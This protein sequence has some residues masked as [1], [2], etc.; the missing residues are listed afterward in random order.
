VDAQRRIETALERLIAAGQEIGLQVAAYVDGE[1]VVDAWA[2]VADP[3]T[4]RRVDGDTLFYLFSCGKGVTATA[5]HLLAERGVVA[6][7]APIAAYWPEFGVRGKE[8][9]TVR[10][11]LTHSAGVPHLPEGT[12]LG[13]LCDWER[14]CEL[15]AGLEPIWEPGTR[16]GYHP[17]VYGFLLGET[18][19]R[20][21]GRRVDQVVREEIAGPLGVAD[22]LAIGVAESMLPRMA[23]HVEAGAEE[24]QKATADAPLETLAP[25]TQANYPGRQL[26]CLPSTCSGTAR[27]LARMYAALARGGELD[28]V[29]IMSKERLGI[30][31]ALAFDGDDALS[32][33][34][35][36]RGLGY[37]LGRPGAPMGDV[38]VF[39]HDGLGETIG[40]A[41]PR[42]RFAFALAKNHLTNDWTPTSTPN[43]LVRE[44]REAL[45]IAD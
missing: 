38:R 1:L 45:G 10:H 2:G 9:I 15:V 31:T 33:H 16:S 8:G 30:A 35:V 44:A 7:D 27:G 29:R 40:F 17:G 34:P 3:E 19:R 20:A 42:H 22:S 4:G 5:V 12:T 24:E 18:V 25:V 41:D 6:Y 32:G 26:A 13:E 37:L 43:L 39:G 23:W 28:G 11:A 21:D 14:M 36:R